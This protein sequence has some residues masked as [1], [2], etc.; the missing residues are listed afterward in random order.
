MPT[1]APDAALL[2][3]TQAVTLGLNAEGLR[4]AA[5]AVTTLPPSQTTCSVAGES[6]LTLIGHIDFLDAP[7]ESAVPALMK[8]AAHCITVKALTSDND[9]VTADTGDVTADKPGRRAAA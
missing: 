2:V 7:K 4:L 6:G 8:L 9:R 3:C 1:L 5:V